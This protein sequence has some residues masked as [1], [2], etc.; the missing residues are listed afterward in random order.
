[1][2][3]E[4]ERKFLVQPDVWRAAISGIEGKPIDQGYLS[5]HAA[6]ESGATRSSTRVR[7]SGEKAWLTIKSAESGMTRQEFEFSISLAEAVEMLASLCMTRVEKTRYAIPHGAHVI[8]LDVF[9]GANAGLVVAEVELASV[10]DVFEAPAWLGEEVTHLKRYY[11]V[12]LAERPYAG[13]SHNEKAGS[14]PEPAKKS[15]GP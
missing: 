1:M 8:E 9:E 3:T 15:W 11:N 12:N 10:D 5:T 6:E 4:I 13:W 14:P 2:G 7:R